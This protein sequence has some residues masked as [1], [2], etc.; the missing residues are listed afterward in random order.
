M[1]KSRFDPPRDVG[2]EVG[3][4]GISTILPWLDSLKLCVVLSPP[5]L[6]VEENPPTPS[7][8]GE[9]PSILRVELSRPTIPCVDAKPVPLCVKGRL[10]TVGPKEGPGVD[11]RPTALGPREGPT[12]FQ[13]GLCERNALNIYT[14]WQ[15][16][17]TSIAIAA[18][19]LDGFF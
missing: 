3:A 4:P 14:K 6:E 17:L 12:L 19:N 1:G 11:E 7:V 10:V 13:V 8:N 15:T 9:R 16:E 2:V 5:I 18:V